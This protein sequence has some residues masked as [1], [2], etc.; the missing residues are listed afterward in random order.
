MSFMKRG[1]NRTRIYYQNYLFKFGHLF[2][3]NRK[4]KK[5]REKNREGG[6]TEREEARVRQKKGSRERDMSN[7]TFI[8]IHLYL[9]S[10]QTFEVIFPILFIASLQ[11][12]VM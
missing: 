10:H 9:L 8:I 2:L 6:R 11:K 4:R 12:E 7:K 1:L 5:V 3:H